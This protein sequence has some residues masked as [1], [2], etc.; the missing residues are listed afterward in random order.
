MVDVG[1][2][3]RRTQNLCGMSVVAG[4]Y[5]RLK[6]YNL[7]EIYHP[8]PKPN[9]NDGG[10]AN[11]SGSEGFSGVVAKDDAGP[12]VTDAVESSTLEPESAARKSEG[13]PIGPVERGCRSDTAHPAVQES[14]EETEEGV[15][16][17]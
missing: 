17:S 8:T 11:A 5:D 9:E 15:H 1:L 12:A 2:T 7:A 4:D 16:S 3:K 6:R 10:I 13:D 14:G